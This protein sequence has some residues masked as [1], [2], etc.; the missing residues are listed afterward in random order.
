MGHFGAGKTSLIRRFVED[1]FESDYKVTIGVHISKKVVVTAPEQDDVN[2]IIWDIEGKEDL[3]DNRSSYLLGT[4]AFIYVQDLSRLHIQREHDM[5]DAREFFQAEY[6][7]ALTAFVGN[8]LDL[9]LEEHGGRTSALD[10][11]DHVVSAKSGE[12][13]NHMFQS[14]AENL[15]NH[16]E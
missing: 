13:V 8:K 3:R 1:A 16:G 2:L 6:P 15:L 10:V 9:F 4:H 12:G 7:T 11:Y 5:D 14:L